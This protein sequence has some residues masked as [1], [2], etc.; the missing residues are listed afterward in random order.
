M[1][2]LTRLFPNKVTIQI[3]QDETLL[4]DW[5]QQLDRDIETLKLQS[6]IVTFRSLVPIMCTI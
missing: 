6:N 4:S 2:Q 3:P 1:K 5:K